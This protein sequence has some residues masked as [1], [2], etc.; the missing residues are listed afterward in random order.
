M[1]LYFPNTYGQSS[2][3]ASSGLLGAPFGALV[4]TLGAFFGRLAAL[5][6]RILYVIFRFGSLGG[7]GLVMPPSV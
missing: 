3:L 2:I 6:R 7:A 1:G 5:L 4:G